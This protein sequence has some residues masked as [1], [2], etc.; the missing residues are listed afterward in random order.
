MTMSSPGG[1]TPIAGK[2]ASRPGLSTRRLTGPGVWGDS[3]DRQA[4]L[5]LLRAAVRDHGISHIDTSDSYGPHIVEETIRE[6]LSPYPAELLI[7]AKVGVVRPDRDRWTPVGRPEY[8]RHAVEGSLRRLGVEQLDVFYLERI[9]T[10]EPMADVRTVDEANDWQECA[11]AL[12]SAY[13]CAYPALP[14]QELTASS[15]IALLKMLCAPVMSVLP[16]AW[17]LRAEA[18]RRLL[19]ALPDLDEALRLCD[20]PM[21]Q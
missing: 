13:R 5:E 7:A 8:L 19:D 2:K 17:E 16:M 21:R 11:V 12:L 10:G 14:A 20:G 9:D 15:R 3:P 6:A 4:A 18:V 1:W